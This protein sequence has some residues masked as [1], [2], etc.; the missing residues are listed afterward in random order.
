MVFNNTLEVLGYFCKF[1]LVEQFL[2]DS[3][4]RS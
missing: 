4:L 3:L 1:I 2:M